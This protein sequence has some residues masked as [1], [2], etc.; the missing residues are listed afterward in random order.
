VKTATTPVHL[1]TAL[2]NW[3]PLAAIWLLMGFELPPVSALMAWR[4]NA[5][6]ST[7][8]PRP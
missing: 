6:P 4:S 5:I 2:L 7:P 3:W 8:R 1:H